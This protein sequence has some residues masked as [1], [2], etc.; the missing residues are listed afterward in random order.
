MTNILQYV[1]NK[2]KVSRKAKKPFGRKWGPFLC[3]VAALFLCMADLTRHLVNDAWGTVCSELPEGQKL[4]I[5]S[6]DGWDPLEP[7]YNKYCFSQNVAN[8]YA[9]DDD[10]LSVYG[11]VFTIFCT[12]SGFVLLFIGLCW[13]ISLPSKVREQWRQIRHARTPP[14]LDSPA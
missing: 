3:I 6:A 11:W 14:L 2:T 12:W 4:G 13:A 8:E 9:G 5:L 10:H 1:Y 7:K